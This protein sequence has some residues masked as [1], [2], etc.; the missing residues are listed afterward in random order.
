M[1]AL[2]LLIAGGLGGLVRGLVVFR[3]AVAKGPVT[4]QT[5]INTMWDTGTS[6]T[7]GA[8]ISLFLHGI[9]GAV[10]DLPILNQV[11]IEGTARTATEGFIAGFGGIAVGGTLWDF[12]STVDFMSLFKKKGTP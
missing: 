2:P 7:I 12:F 5:V 9:G 8:I 6:V 3:S 11:A 10:L 1:D 4:Q